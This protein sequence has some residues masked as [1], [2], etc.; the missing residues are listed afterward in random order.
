MNGIPTLVV[1]LYAILILGL[2]VPTRAAE[3]P[4]FPSAVGFGARASGGRGGAV[5]HVT[6]LDD[7]GLGSFRDAVAKPKRTVV[8]DVAG[9]VDLRSP[10]SVASDLTVAGQ[11]APGEGIA[12]RNYEV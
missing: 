8:F 7:A 4:A 12:I 10:V 3:A 2:S 11:T 6:N 9:Y 5:A 1:S